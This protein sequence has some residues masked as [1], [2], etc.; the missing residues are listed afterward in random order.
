MDIRSTRNSKRAFQFE[1]PGSYLPAVSSELL[2]S[3]DKPAAPRTGNGSA[4]GRMAARLTTSDYGCRS[5]TRGA[6]AGSGLRYAAFGSG[7]EKGRGTRAVAR[8]ARALA[9]RFCRLVW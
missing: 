7:T 6:G 4:A 8:R 1:S 2:W 3:D 9:A 5:G